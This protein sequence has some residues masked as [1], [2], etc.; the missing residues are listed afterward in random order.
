MLWLLAAAVTAGLVVGLVRGGSVRH[1]VAVHVP[2][3]VPAALLAAGSTQVVLA[4]LPARQRA[5]ADGP[6][7]LAAVV[8]AAAALAGC[9]RRS[10]VLRRAALVAL[11]GGGLN[12][13]VMLPNGGMPVSVH[14]ARRFD[15][16]SVAEPKPL[17]RHVIADA[18]TPLAP[19]G[20]VLPVRLGPQRGLVSAGDLLLLLA[21]GLAV[22]DLLTRHPSKPQAGRPAG[23]FPTSERRC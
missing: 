8:L 18:S 4:L 6:L 11:L 20:D 9:A 1:A 5:G 17:G 23:N 3:G 22:H 14:A 12:A 21:A 16:A 13:A 7:L 2:G 19:L 10:P 15:V